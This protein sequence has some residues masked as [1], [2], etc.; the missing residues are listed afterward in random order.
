MSTATALF[1]PRRRVVLAAL[2]LVA[3]GRPA[4]PQAT[5]LPAGTTVLAF[6]DSITA[7]TGAEPAQSYPTQIA[8]LTGWS[9]VNG[10]MPGDTSAQAVAR[11]PMLLAE[12]KPALVIV[13]I[14][15]NDFLRRVA[16]EETEM[17]LRRIAAMVRDANAQI[18]L[19]AVPQPSVGA[20]VGL[21]LSDHPMYARLAEELQLPLH[22]QGWSRVLG[23]EKL[24]S[25]PIHANAA[26][27]RAFAEGLVQTLRSV[28]LLS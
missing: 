27:Y 18:L 26:G 23:D 15:G 16:T 1:R 13:S 17:N 24:K 11:L 5:A 2:L 9:V 6:G 3:C 19:V 7:G 21:G 8:A 14:G 12:H 22:A 10:G 4:T 20:A 28:K 25:D